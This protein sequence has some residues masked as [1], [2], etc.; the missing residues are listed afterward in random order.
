MRMLRSLECI[1]SVVRA[2]IEFSLE[3]LIFLVASIFSSPELCMFR[4]F[5]HLLDGEKKLSSSFHPT[6]V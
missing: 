1:L 3:L 2:S 4:E 6:I 5:V